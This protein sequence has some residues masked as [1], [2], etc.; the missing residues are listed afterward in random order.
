MVE[1]RKGCPKCG[2]WDFV[3]A[4]E[5]SDVFE[6]RG[7]RIVRKRNVKFVDFDN[8]CM[9]CGHKWSTCE[10]VSVRRFCGDEWRRQVERAL[11]ET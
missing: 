5:A 9:D 2:S 4:F 1:V 11:S 7:S 10:C 3:G 6:K 8:V